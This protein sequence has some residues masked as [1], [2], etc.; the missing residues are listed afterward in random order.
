MFRLEDINRVVWVVSWENM[1]LRRSFF[2]WLPFFLEGT[3]NGYSDILKLK[4]FILI[5]DRNCENDSFPFFP[6]FLS[7]ASLLKLEI[8]DEETG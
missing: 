3:N 7:S 4:L 5:L 8:D 1:R 6:L 2:F